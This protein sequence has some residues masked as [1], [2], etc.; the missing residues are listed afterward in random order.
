MEKGDV[1]ERTPLTSPLNSP[2]PVSLESPN[3]VM[4]RWDVLVEKI[5]VNDLEDL[6]RDPVIKMRYRAVRKALLDSNSS[7][8]ERVL[9]RLNWDETELRNLNEVVYPTDEDKIR[10]CFS[11]QDFIL[12]SANDF[13]YKFEANVVHL[14]IWSKIFIP[15]YINDNTDQVSPD[16]G[17][18]ELPEMNMEMKARIEY[19]LSENLNK[20]GMEEERDYVWFINHSRLQSIRSLSHIHLIVRFRDIPPIEN[21]PRVTEAA[22]ER[23]NYFI[24]GGVFGPVP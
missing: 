21:D 20:L 8:N 6:K 14:L 9:K 12:V 18:Q 7:I 17:K 3:S 2:S 23:M 10:A 13:P 15:L 11:R 24:N 4:T 19:F 1:K 22:E 5:R 16:G